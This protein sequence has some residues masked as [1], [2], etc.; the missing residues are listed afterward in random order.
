MGELDYRLITLSLQAW[1]LS[2]ALLFQFYLLI[3][4]FD[5]PRVIS[6]QSPEILRW[7]NEIKLKRKLEWISCEIPNKTRLNSA[8]PRKT[9]QNTI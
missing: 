9:M 7:K 6:R 2:E 1:N 3:A 5:N 4:R 8:L